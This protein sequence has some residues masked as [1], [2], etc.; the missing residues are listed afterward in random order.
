[1]K[2]RHVVFFGFGKTQSPAGIAEVIRRFAELKALGPGVDD[3]EWGENSSW[4]RV[5]LIPLSCLS[6]MKALLILRPKTGRER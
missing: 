2:L 3:F 6:V 4:P 5:I 1:M